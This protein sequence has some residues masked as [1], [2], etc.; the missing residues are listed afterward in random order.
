MNETYDVEAGRHR[1][2]HLL[3]LTRPLILEEIVEQMGFAE[4]QVIDAL[5]WLVGQGRIKTE[6]GNPQ[7]WTA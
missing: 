5:N 4:A 1:I 7:R 3:K 6:N 2:E